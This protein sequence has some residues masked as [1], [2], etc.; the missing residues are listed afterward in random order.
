M[1]EK[2]QEYIDQLL[3]ELKA[4]ESRALTIKNE[5]TVPFSFFRESFD[6]T[7]RVMR[8]LHEM[9]VLQIDDMKQQ[10]ERLVLFL[11][12]SENRRKTEAKEAIEEKIANETAQTEEVSAKVTEIEIEQTPPPQRN[13]YAEKIVLPEYKNPRKVEHTPTPPS[14]VESVQEEVTQ[15]EIAPTRTLNDTIQVAPTALDLKKGISLNDRFLFQ[16]ELFNNSRT[17][18][19][20]TISKLN[21][22]NHYNDA[23]RFL[24]ETTPWDFEN[25]TVVMFLESI[26][27]GF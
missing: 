7:Q 19:D 5:D 18:M 12:E 14:V 4:L 2:R 8:L 3:Q 22:F 11:S 10:M 20:S 24:R 9:E 15:E 21:S 6:K 27:K 25:E 13:A 23:E 26:K 17:E 1:T 16:R